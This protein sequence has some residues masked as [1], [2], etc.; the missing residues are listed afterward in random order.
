MARAATTRAHTALHRFAA[1]SMTDK[2]ESSNPGQCAG[3][4]ACPLYAA[5]RAA[6]AAAGKKEAT[7]MAAAMQAE[8]EAAEIASIKAKVCYK[9]QRGVDIRHF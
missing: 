5:A 8:A 3:N 9:S 6:V 1:A 2:D 7:R 4:D